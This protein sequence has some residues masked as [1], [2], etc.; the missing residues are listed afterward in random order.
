MT[1]NK[2][3]DPEKLIKENRELRRRIR[4]AEHYMAVASRWGQLKAEE[5]TIAMI[6]GILHGYID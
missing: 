5:E 3:P 4:K 6:K 1:E 2:K